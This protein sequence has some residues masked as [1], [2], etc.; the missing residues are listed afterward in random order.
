MEDMLESLLQCPTFSKTFI[1]Y[2]YREEL[3]SEYCYSLKPNISESMHL[4]FQNFSR[5]SRLDILTKYVFIGTKISTLTETYSPN[6]VYV[7]F[8]AMVLITPIF[9]QYF[10]GGFG[11]QLTNE[12]A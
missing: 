2:L 12:S 6:C 5:Y 7:P 4:F 10:N 8:L 9:R 1:S 3:Q 11:D